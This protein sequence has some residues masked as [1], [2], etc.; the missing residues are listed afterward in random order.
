MEKTETNMAETYKQAVVSVDAEFVKQ[1]WASFKGKVT[2]ALT[3]LKNI[4][5][6]SGDGSSPFDH[7]NIDPEEVT[8][9]VSVLKEA[10]QAV[11]E[12]HVR[13]EVIRKHEE[14]EEK[15]AALVEKDEEYITE[16]ETKLRKGMKR[17]S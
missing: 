6:R 9:V 14:D 2:R 4:I 8:T 7:D 12:L 1:V 13:F 15:E 5:R 16:L 3:T 17:Y 11:D 10:K